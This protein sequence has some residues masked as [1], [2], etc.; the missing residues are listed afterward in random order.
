MFLIVNVYLCLVMDL[1]FVCCKIVAM[2][3]ET[4]TLVG[5][6]YNKFIYD[7]EIDFHKKNSAN[8]NLSEIMHLSTNDYIS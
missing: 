8:K 2:E 7:N 6:F 5:F 4:Y 3:N 1:V